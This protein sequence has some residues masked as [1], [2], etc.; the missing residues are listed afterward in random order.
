MVEIQSFIA[1]V[2]VNC[3]NDVILALRLGQSALTLQA[4]SPAVYSK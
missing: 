4:W 2:D 3:W 1:A